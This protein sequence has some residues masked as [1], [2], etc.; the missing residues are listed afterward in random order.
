MAGTHAKGVLAAG[1]EPELIAALE[2][3]LPGLELVDRELEIVRPGGKGRSAALVGRAAGGMLVLIEELE[4]PVEKTALRALEL[5]ALAREH[6]RELLGR[7]ECALGPTLVLLAGEEVHEL[8]TLLAPLLGRELQLYAC[9]QL[10]THAQTRLALAPV[11]GSHAA[12]PG[13]R[14]EFL[15][16]LDPGS[17]PVAERLWERLSA[18]AL[19]ARAEIGLAGV[20]WSDARG[21][22]CSLARGPAGLSGRLA[23]LDEAI[24]LGN[25]ADG[26]GFLDAVLALHL[27]RAGMR[28][29]NPVESLPQAAFDPRT[30]LLSEAE[31]AAFHDA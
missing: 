18:P 26:R 6:A 12:V 20:R 13:S 2:L 3:H 14:A 30:P 29:E 4:G 9:T 19:G 25:E 8:G 31:I 17:R 23:G 5:A 27:E 24:E 15:A 11:R 1:S 22:L 21:A 28:M 16:E 7:F 10:R